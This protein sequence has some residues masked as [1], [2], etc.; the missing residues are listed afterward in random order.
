MGA[1]L[2][3]LLFPHESGLTLP[4]FEP[5]F[6][7]V[8]VLLPLPGDACHFSN[9]IH[10]FLAFPQDLGTNTISWDQGNTVSFHG[11]LLSVK[12][13]IFIQ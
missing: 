9:G 2:G 1:Q 4:V 6:G 10:H 7:A 13:T 5:M 11:D 12:A 3:H 8:G